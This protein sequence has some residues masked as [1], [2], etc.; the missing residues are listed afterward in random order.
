[1]LDTKGPAITPSVGVAQA[2]NFQPTGGAKAAITGDFML[3]ASEVN[4]GIKDKGAS[5]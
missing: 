4:P 5:R 1:M 2:I 3:I